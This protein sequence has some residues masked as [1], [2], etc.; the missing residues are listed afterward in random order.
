MAETEKLLGKVGKRAFAE[1]FVLLG[2]DREVLVE[3]G[4]Q[5]FQIYRLAQPGQAYYDSVAEE[6]GS[7]AAIDMTSKF[8]TVKAQMMMIDKQLEDQKAAKEG[9]GTVAEILERL[10]KV[11]F[12]KLEVETVEGFSG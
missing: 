7:L 1:A 3:R 5:N 2:K 9:K 6:G 11:K 8:L 10:D 4:E 12:E